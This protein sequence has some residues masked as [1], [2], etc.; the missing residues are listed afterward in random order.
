MRIRKPFG[1]V[2]PFPLLLEN[3]VTFDT[4]NASSFRSIHVIWIVFSLEVH[5]RLRIWIIL[6]VE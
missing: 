6:L 1:D 3:A 2:V 5:D 4:P